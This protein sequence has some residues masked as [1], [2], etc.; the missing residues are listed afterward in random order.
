[1]AVRKTVTWPNLTTLE[2]YHTAIFAQQ[3]SIFNSHR[4]LCTV[5][6]PFD[7]RATVASEARVLNRNDR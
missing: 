3:W 1:M 5:R 6:V 2:D 4:R 7:Y